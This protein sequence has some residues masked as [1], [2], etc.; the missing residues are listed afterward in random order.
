MKKLLFALAILSTVSAF[1]AGEIELGKC[2]ENGIGIES[3][4]P[5]AEN[6][7]S[8]Y[9]GGVSL[10]AYDIGEPAA[11]SQGIAI[12]YYSPEELPEGHVSRN[13][14]VITYLSGVDLKNAKSVYDA[15]TGV[16]MK[17]P[18]RNYNPETGGTTPG[19]IEVN[20]KMVNRGT[21]SE[22]HVISAKKIK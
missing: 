14:A 10:Y 13:C 4:I 19:M 11:A 6:Q 21:L 3:L 5:G 7:R 2:S 9:N 16:T 12:T 15:K 8:V 1:A 20:I 17:I 18:V 22:G